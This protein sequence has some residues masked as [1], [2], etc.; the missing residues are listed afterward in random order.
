M[1]EYR[2]HLDPRNPGQFLACCGLF[3]LA[4]LVEPGGLACFHKDGTEFALQSTAVLPPAEIKLRTDSDLN[5]KPYD[6]TFEPLELVVGD[7]CLTLNWW[8]NETLTGKSVLKTWAGK[9]TPRH[10]LSKLLKLLDHSKRAEQ[11]F[12]VSAHTTTRFGVD[13]R[14]AWEPQDVGYSPTD[15]EE[16]DAVTF[17]WVEVL[18]V[19]GL[20]GFR[21]AKLPKAGS[22]YRYS[23]WQEPLPLVAAR[24]ACAAPWDGLSALSFE[25]PM[26]AR[27]KSYRTFLFAKGVDHA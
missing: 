18:A 3:E 22:R 25:F 9:Q 6:A 4:E 19:I 13:A 17:P 5:G 15:T 8:L 14:S 11:L 23:T 21:P 26:A 10:M 1:P 24:L 27:G 12:E 7:R 20:Q 16:E 2:L